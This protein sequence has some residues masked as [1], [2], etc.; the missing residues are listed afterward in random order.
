M[1]PPIHMLQFV[2][3]LLL[4]AVPF[5]FGEAGQTE[6]A[7]DKRAGLSFPDSRWIPIA[8]PNPDTDHR[9]QACAWD[10]VHD[11]IYMYG[12]A[13]SDGRL[14]CYDPAQD[15]WSVLASMLE[16]HNSIKGLYCRGKLYALAGYDTTYHPKTACEAYDIETNTWY[17]TARLPKLTMAYEAVVWRDSLI[18][19]MGGFDLGNP[20]DTVWVYNPFRDTWTLAS[21]LLS[22]CDMGDAC[23]IGDTIYFAGGLNRM[24]STRDTCL[25]IG[26]IN[27]N[28]PEQID[29]SWGPRLPEARFNGPTIALGGKV[30]FFGG[31]LSGSGGV[32]TPRGWAYDPRAATFDSLPWLPS[33][34]PYGTARCCFGVARD[35]G[36]EIYKLAGDDNGDQEGPDRSYYKYTVPRIRDVGLSIGSPRDTVDSG[37]TVRP[38]SRLVNYGFINE[39]VN[40]VRMRIEDV[41][42][43]SGGPFVLRPLQD[44][45][46]EFDSMA[47]NLPMGD[48]IAACSVMGGQTGDT[49]GRAETDSFRVDQPVTLVESGRKTPAAL[50]LEVLSPSPAHGWLNVRLTLDRAADVSLT[51]CDATGRVARTLVNAKQTAGVHDL[52]FPI[53]HSSSTVASGVYFLLLRTREPF[54]PGPE[55]VRRKKVVI[56][57]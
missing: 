32:S 55:S 5:A 13:P 56:A 25:R 35:S 36:G 21:R 54:G 57:E 34:I 2:G 51:L 43:D 20:T 1:R 39:Y 11:R 45:T 44:T 7:S 23:I 37:A 9:W 52:S 41:Y 42:L 18:Y 3:L 38:A 24:T 26:A 31:F 29:W 16:D 6:K 28:S 15:T 14:Y 50:G 17:Y 49:W 46:L 40:V 27:P 48:H 30:Y 12:G 8:H 19:V 33:E 53:Q 4:C 10:P 22:P 47:V